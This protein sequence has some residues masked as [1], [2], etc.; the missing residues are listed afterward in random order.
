[1]LKSLNQVVKQTGDDERWGA[2]LQNGKDNRTF[3][4]S[5]SCITCQTFTFFYQHTLIFQNSASYACVSTPGLR[6]MTHS[7]THAYVQTR[8]HTY[9]HTQEQSEVWSFGWMLLGDSTGSPI[10]ISCKVHITDKNG[11]NDTC[12][13]SLIKATESNILFMAPEYI[14]YEA[15]RIIKAQHLMI[16]AKDK[17]FWSLQIYGKNKPGCLLVLSRPAEELIFMED[18]IQRSNRLQ[19]I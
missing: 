18:H 12:Q 1:M 7:P 17:P 13:V 4:R 19:L 6:K 14:A 5:N 8:T 11:I 10:W 15:R 2:I 16:I 3:Y 9:T